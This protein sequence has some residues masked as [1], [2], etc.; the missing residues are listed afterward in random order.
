MT[1]ETMNSEKHINFKCAVLRGT[2]KAGDF[3]DVLGRRVLF[4][5][6]T[7]PGKVNTLTVGH[8]KSF[9]HSFIQS[10]IYHKTKCKYKDTD[11]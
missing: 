1:S 10:F 11:K 5:I 3:L 9:S 2:I 8:L 7:G 6:N 4:T